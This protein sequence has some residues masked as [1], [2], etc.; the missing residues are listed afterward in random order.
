M[1]EIYNICAEYLPVKQ[2]CLQ[3]LR[4]YQLDNSADLFKNALD[5]VD[6]TSYSL[7]HTHEY[8][9]R[10]INS[11][12]SVNFQILCRFSEHVISALIY[13]VGLI[14]VKR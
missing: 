13:F 12:C 11:L 8:I 6:K 5:I 1:A 3:Q 4:L 7:L 2:K 10:D 14:S 9:G